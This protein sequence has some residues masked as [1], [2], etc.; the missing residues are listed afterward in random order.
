M[1]IN[2]LFEIVYL[3]LEREQMTAAQLAARFE[4]S[5]RTIYRDIDTLS[6][7]GI[8]IYASK[9]K[10]GGIRLLPD[11][12]LNKSLLS[13]REQNE[14]LFALQS[15][16]ATS[17]G[18]NAVLD[19]L[20]T[21][22]HR[23]G[24]DWI[25]VDFSRWGSGGG[26]RE[27]FRLLKAAILERRVVAFTY[28]SSY[29]LASE[30]RV[31]PRMLRFKG[32]GWYLQGYCL[33]K[34]AYRTFKISRIENLRA[35]GEPF[36]PR[37]DPLPELDGETSLP[38]GCLV[39][40][41]L[42]FSPRAAFRVWDEFEHSQVTHNPDGSFLVRA[43]YPEAGWVYGFLLSF[44]EDVRVLSPERVGLALREQAKKIAALYG[45]G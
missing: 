21:L 28:Y 18:D 2:R 17:A 36:L 14:I 24:A 15:L 4:V 26:E 35:T 42:W 20:S 6:G 41:K 38:S 32:G 1:Q 33:A 40:L 34:Q 30:R 7:A 31:E 16:R 13:E 19:R 11:F 12:V 3:L 37:T 23:E 8:P 43:A 39:S 29:G 22:F 9:G 25:D 5:P 27:T 44:G 10:G 45:G